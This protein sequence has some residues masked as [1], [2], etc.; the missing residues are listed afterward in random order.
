G[1]FNA[2]PLPGSRTDELLTFDNTVANRNKSASAVY[3]YWSGAWRQVGAGANNVG[4]N[5][6]L[7]AGTGVIIR[8]ATNSSTVVWTNA[9]NY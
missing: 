3:Y 4:S 9:P 2:S 6:V 5:A 1:A 8:K 7:G